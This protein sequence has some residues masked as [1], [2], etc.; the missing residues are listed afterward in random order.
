MLAYQINSSWHS[1]E[2]LG[3]TRKLLDEEV[4]RWGNRF[5]EKFILSLNKEEQNNSKIRTY[6]EARGISRRQHQCWD[7]QSR[8][9]RR[10]PFFKWRLSFL[11]RI[12]FIITMHDDKWIVVNS[13]DLN[14]MYEM[15][16]EKYYIKR[17]TSFSNK[18]QQATEWKWIK[19]LADSRWHKTRLIDYACMII[20]F[21]YF[22]DCTPK[23]FLLYWAELSWRPNEFDFW[24]YWK[25]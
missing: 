16:M 23:F 22:D 24:E 8:R 2:K 19:L 15:R 6:H 1:S 7:S 9:H 17:R 25:N 18:C 11:G 13:A 14:W 10:Y 4:C 20:F 12:Q 3:L 5:N 21:R